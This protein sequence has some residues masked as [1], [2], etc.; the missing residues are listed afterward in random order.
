M[1]IL[2]VHFVKALSVC[3]H[4]MFIPLVR[5][6][7]ILYAHFVYAPSECSP[8][9]MLILHALFCTLIMYA[10]SHCGRLARQIFPGDIII[11]VDGTDVV[12]MDPVHVQGM[13]QGAPYSPVTLIYQRKPDSD[14]LVITLLRAVTKMDSTAVEMM[15]GVV[16]AA[17]RPSFVSCFSL[18]F[19][20]SLSVL[21][22]M[23]AYLLDFVRRTIRV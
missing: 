11:D 12:G 14:P 2:Y 23:S 22:S 3:S 17:V 1:L 6:L 4:C 7:F 20:Y 10:Y 9:G 16:P 13:L 5:F 21:M 15:H 18:L 19:P 8:L